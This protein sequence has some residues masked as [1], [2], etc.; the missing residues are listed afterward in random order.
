MHDYRYSVISKGIAEGM[1][2]GE[3]AHHLRLKRP[4]LTR[5]TEGL[6]ADVLAFMGD[7]VLDDALEAPAWRAIIIFKNEQ[8]ACRADRRRW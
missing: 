7:G 6:A 2:K 8:A 1:S 3:M 4:Q 5:L